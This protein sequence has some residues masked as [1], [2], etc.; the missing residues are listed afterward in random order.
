MDSSV[1]PFFVMMTKSSPSPLSASLLMA[2]LTARV[3]RVLASSRV[4]LSL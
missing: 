2:A 3:T 4:R 1:M